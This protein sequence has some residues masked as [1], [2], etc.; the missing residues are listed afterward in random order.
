MKAGQDSILTYD[1]WPGHGVHRNGYQHIGGHRR[2]P[3]SPPPRGG[4]LLSRAPREG[5]PGA[6]STHYGLHP[7]LVADITGLIF[8]RPRHTEAASLGAM[9]LAVTSVG[10]FANPQEAAA[11]LNPPCAR[12]RPRKAYRR[13]YLSMYE[14]YNKLYERVTTLFPELD[15]GV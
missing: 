2:R 1:P 15:Q 6:G 9:V 8:A 10:A 4:L 13:L 11:R 12:F 3:G 5:P 7:P 14:V